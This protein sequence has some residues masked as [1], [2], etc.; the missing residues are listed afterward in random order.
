MY[1]VFPHAQNAVD[2]WYWL[3][4]QIDPKG[5]IKWEFVTWQIPQ[6]LKREK[7]LACDGVLL[8]FV[9][10]LS[11][12]RRRI[13]SRGFSCCYTMHCNVFV[14]IFQRT[15]DKHITLHGVRT[16]KTLIWIT[17]VVKT[18][19]LITTGLLCGGLVAPHT[20]SQYEVDCNPR[21]EPDHTRVICNV[22]TMTFTHI[23]QISSGTGDS[24]QE[25]LQWGGKG[26]TSLTTE[27]GT[28]VGE[29][30]R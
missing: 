14:L 7:H 12:L 26:Y 21:S 1:F 9:I 16:Q 5:I 29:L 30:V 10:A 6:I 22:V 13:K 17:S 2:V 24:Q 8:K 18:W 27:G 19:K 11:K 20:V 23:R 4:T 25:A 15:L 3:I 28:Q